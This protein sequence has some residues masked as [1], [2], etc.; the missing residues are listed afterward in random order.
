MLLVTVPALDTLPLKERKN[1]RTLDNIPEL[2]IAPTNPRVA[3]FV[4]APLF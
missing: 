4:N 1:A 2:E 3:I